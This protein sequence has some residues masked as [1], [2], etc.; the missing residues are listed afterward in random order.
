[1]PNR[2][3]TLYHIIFKKTSKTKDSFFLKHIKSITE[4]LEEAKIKITTQLSE[5]QDYRYDART[6]CY[7]LLI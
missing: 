5:N 7:T 6:F 2:N 1:M 4:N 3:N